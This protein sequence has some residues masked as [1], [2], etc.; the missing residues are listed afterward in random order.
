MCQGLSSLP[1][2]PHVSA[3]PAAIRISA[4]SRRVITPLRLRATDVHCVSIL[5]QATFP[6]RTRGAV[7]RGIPLGV[8][9]GSAGAGATSPTVWSLP[10]EPATAA[11]VRQRLSALLTATPPTQLDDVMLAA[12]ELVTNAVVH[13]EGPVV[14]TVWT[15][16]AIRVEVGDSGPGTPQLLSGRGFHESGRGLLIVDAVASRWGV[17]PKIPGPGKAVWFEVE[18]P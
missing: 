18:V 7:A 1:A 3:P 14:V 5:G 6:N 2:F 9:S 8:V 13:G 17:L 15:V 12:S 10:S 4:G 16:P 11:D